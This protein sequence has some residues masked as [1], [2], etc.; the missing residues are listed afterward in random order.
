[1]QENLQKVNSRV[2][3]VLPWGSEI[4]KLPSVNISLHCTLIRITCKHV[5]TKWPLQDTILCGYMAPQVL[6]PCWHGPPLHI[7]GFYVLCI[8]LLARKNSKDFCQDEDSNRELLLCE[9]IFICSRLLVCHL[10]C[11]QPISLSQNVFFLNHQFGNINFP[12]ISYYFHIPIIFDYLDIHCPTEVM[13]VGTMIFP[14]GEQFFF[15]T[16]TLQI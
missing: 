4:K 9:M 6:L 11:Q 3:I 10:R 16:W 5:I 7:L 12:S 2:L 8:F 1:M 14:V 15:P 13:A